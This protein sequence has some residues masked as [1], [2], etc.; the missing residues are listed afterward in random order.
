[1]RNPFPQLALVAASLIAAACGSAG[2]SRDADRA[3]LITVFDSTADSIVARV[4]GEV[5]T[6]AVRRLVEE[7]RIA[8]AMDDTSL[9]TNVFEFDVDVADRI[10]VYDAASHRI[11]LFGRDGAL[12]RTVGRQG[13]GPGEFAQG[14]GMI[15]LPDTGLAVWDSRNARVSFFTSSGDFRASWRTPAGFST[16]NG[17]ITDRS[18]AYWLRRPVTAPREGEILGRMGLVR[19]GP[20]GALSDSTAPP[21][22][23]VSRDTYLA[24]SS[25]GRSRSSTSNSFA[26]NYH[27]QWHPDGYFVA[28]HG[29][30]YEIVLARREGRPVVIRRS[31]PP[32]TIPPDERNEEQERITWQMR[33]VQPGWSWSGPAI[34]ETKA[35]LTQLFIARDGRIWARV[36]TPSERIPEAELD[37]PREKGPPVRHF[38]SPVVWEVFAPSGRF[39]GRIPFPPRTTLM[40][41]D[42]DIVW[43]LGRD[44]NDLP[45]LVRFRVDPVL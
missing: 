17:L 3:G 11:F 36:A 39:L 18:G 22:L 15:A 13:A 40:E 27:W 32:V 8:P 6:T 19:L 14:N 34:P 25:D 44:E 26:P 20:D 42:G 5:A 30:R 1:M 10:W 4:D 31:M 16:S 38:R 2:A 21:D 28:A 9:F 45:A 37:A 43:A 33:T 29:G 12:I 41:A 35:P 7:M 24:V 23:P